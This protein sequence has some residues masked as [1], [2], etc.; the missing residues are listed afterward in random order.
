MAKAKKRVKKKAANS[1]SR[2]VKTSAPRRAPAPKKTSD[3][4]DLLNRFVDKNHI[5]FRITFMI[6][7]A[8]FAL[9]MFEGKISV[10]FDDA[11]YIQ[12]AQNYVDDFFGFWHGANAPLYVFFLTIPVA[13]FGVNLTIIK[14]LGVALFVGTIHLIY[15][16]FQDRI[17]GLILF[18]AMFL[19]VT[20][21]AVLKYASLTYQEALFI[22]VQAGFIWWF[23]KFIDKNPTD[24][25]SL[26]PFDFRQVKPWLLLGLFLFTL[27]FTRT[28]AIAS[29][30]ACIVYFLWYKQYRSV[31]LT[32]LSTALFY[33]LVTGVKKVLWGDV[34]QFGQA[35]SILQIDP[36]DA[37]KG[38]EDFMGFVK[39]FLGN[40]EVFFSQRLLTIVSIRPESALRD[41]FFTILTV[42]PI[43]IGIIASI[44]KKH[45]YLF[46]TSLYCLAVCA[47]TFIVLQIQWGQL[48]FILIY[49]PYFLILSFYGLYQILKIKSLHRLQ[50]ILFIPFFYLVFINLDNTFNKI[51]AHFPETEAYFRG[52][53]YKGFTPDWVNYLKMSEWCGK[54]L[55]EEAFVAC[56]KAPMS[57][58]YAD[59]KKFYNIA[60]ALSDV[61]AEEKLKQLKEKGVTH[62]IIA[63]LRIDPSR[64]TDRVINTIHRYV[65]PISQK[66]PNTLRRVHQVGSSEPA[67]LYEINYPTSN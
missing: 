43:G 59:G 26:K 49:L 7:G 54:N 45:K 12:S 16:A 10:G 65:Q 25:I 51:K 21:W 52:D 6:I 38:Y 44:I 66:Y 47:L 31:L 24:R 53:M 41:T 5:I 37:S 17:P 55:P 23:F 56:R 57:F 64:K 18:L 20:N 40:I 27:H 29:V 67:T 61:S 36:Y 14:M 22:F 50:L 2:R 15:R 33:F 32:I 34:S 58:I 19:F 35:Q 28:V 13:L 9:L 46:F 11:L 63:N 3:L 8:A 39:R 62:I 48:R 42:I 1:T 4:F 30:G 60:R